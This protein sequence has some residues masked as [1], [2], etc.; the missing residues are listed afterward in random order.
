MHATGSWIAPSA[1][2]S[3]LVVVV[4]PFVPVTPALVSSAAQG[5]GGGSPASRAQRI[6]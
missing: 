2:A 1:S 5:G 6:W 3:Q 4:L